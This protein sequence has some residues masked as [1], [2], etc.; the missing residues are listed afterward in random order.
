MSVILTSSICGQDDYVPFAKTNKFWFYDIYQDFETNRVVNSYVIWIGKDTMIDDKIYYNLLRSNLDGL[1]PSPT[2]YNF[3]P[4]I[5]YRFKDKN[6]IGLITE[7]TLN[8]K[9]FI[10]YQDSLK[11]LYDFNL[12]ISQRLDSRLLSIIKPENWPEKDSL[13]KITEIKFEESYNINR[14]TWVFNGPL[15]YG[16]PFV[17][18][19]RLIEGIGISTYNGFYPSYDILYD[20]CEGALEQCN[21][22]SST[23]ND[24][25]TRSDKILIYPNPA[26]DFI[27]FHN[28]TH[29]STSVNGYCIRDMSNQVLRSVQELQSETNY[30]I[31]TQDFPSGMYIIQFLKDEKIVQTEKFIISN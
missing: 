6:L 10:K 24:R 17:T 23:K 26:S 5:P 28:T 8:K 7:D 9:V 31:H 13:G 1:S 3:I 4:Y 2:N 27:T 12:N 21:I 18:D 30:I 19:M 15:V 29:N 22:I 20:Y 16:M 25:D 11:L 14:K